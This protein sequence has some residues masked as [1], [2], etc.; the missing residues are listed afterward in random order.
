MGKRK[1]NE[2]QTMK[3]RKQ[4]KKDFVEQSRETINNILESKEN[5]MSHIGSKISKRANDTNHILEGIE[6]A[7]KTQ[8][9]RI[10]SISSKKGKDTPNN[11]TIELM[12]K[13]IRECHKAIEIMKTQ[14]ESERIELERLHLSVDEF[15]AGTL[16]QIQGIR[17]QAIK[18]AENEGKGKSKQL[19]FNNEKTFTSDVLSVNIFEAQDKRIQKLAPA[20]LYKKKRK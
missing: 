12:K 13:V 9:S 19:I 14:R 16:Q 3:K 2:E 20:T 11:T 7:L 1:L 4:T 5:L 8:E 10:K 6:E 18:V 15:V 17:L